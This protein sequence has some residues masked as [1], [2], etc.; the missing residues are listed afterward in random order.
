ME[1]RVEGRVEGRVVEF[2]AAGVVS[3]RSSQR[4][5]CCLLQLNAATLLHSS[6]GRFAIVRAVQKPR[7]P[8]LDA[9]ECWAAHVLEGRAP[10]LIDNGWT[11]RS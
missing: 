2:Q 3:D 5:G 7:K 8:S 9:V 10:H 11:N 6:R 4:G 1:A